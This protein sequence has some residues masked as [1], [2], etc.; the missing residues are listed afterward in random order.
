AHWAALTNAATP[1][2]ALVLA[3]RLRLLTAV[4]E[5]PQGARGLN[6]RI[7]ELLASRAANAGARRAAAIGPAG[8]RYFH[9]RLLLVTENSTRHRLFNGDI[10]IC[11]EGDDGTPMAWFPG[12]D[13]Q[14]PRP[15][16]PTAL[17]A[18]ESAFAM[19]VHKA[20]GSEFDEVWLVLPV[21]FNRVLSRELVYTGITRARSRLHLAGSEAVLREALS[22]HAGRW[23]G[24]GWRL[25]S[26]SSS[27]VAPPLPESSEEVV[28]RSLF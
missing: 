13:A 11:L 20:Q 12:V 26:N 7:E 8:N 1:A 16:H 4:R 27:A 5:G 19:T 23:S 22:R 28:Q 2:K 17:P 18:H 9:G 15:F 25:G 6:A 10:G 24:L 3:N 21:R 14:S